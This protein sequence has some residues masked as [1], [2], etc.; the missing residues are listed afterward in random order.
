MQLEKL[1][2]RSAGGVKKGR[3]SPTRGIDD[4]TMI[5]QTLFFHNN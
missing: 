4:F 2:S 1:E 5:R 3:E